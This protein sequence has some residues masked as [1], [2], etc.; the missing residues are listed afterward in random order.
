MIDTIRY[1]VYII[2]MS[3]T[4]LITSAIVI[5]ALVVILGEYKDPNSMRNHIERKRARERADRED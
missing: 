5:F 1:M 4:I 3:I 2:G